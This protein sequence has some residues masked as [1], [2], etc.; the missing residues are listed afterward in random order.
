MSCS[1]KMTNKLHQLQTCF[2][3]ACI[4]ANISEQMIHAKINC[5]LLFITYIQLA[6]LILPLEVRVV[7]RYM[8]KAFEKVWNEELIHKLSQIG[9]YGE[10]LALISSFLNNSFSA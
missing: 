2:I 7:F 8:S 6:I 1:Q 4:C 5:C 3:I 9:I 10:D